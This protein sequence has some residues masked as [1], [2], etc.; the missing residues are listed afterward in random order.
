MDW[1]RVLLKRSQEVNVKLKW[2][3]IDNEADAYIRTT[4]DVFI[5]VVVSHW[6]I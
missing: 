2:I 3:I 4:A 1:Y 6:L 5:I